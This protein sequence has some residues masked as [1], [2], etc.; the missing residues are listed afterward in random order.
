MNKRVF[1]EQ[2]GI[3]LL[4]GAILFGALP[5]VVFQ[6]QALY[7]EQELIRQQHESR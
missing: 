7:A 4:S 1:F 2:L 6:I 3:V 5:N